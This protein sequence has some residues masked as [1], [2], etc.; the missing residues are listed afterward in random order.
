MS[1]HD[2]EMRQALADLLDEPTTDLDDVCLAIAVNQRLTNEVS[3]DTAIALYNDLSEMGNRGESKIG[4][5]HRDSLR[6]KYADMHPHDLM[7][8]MRTASIGLRQ[9]YADKLAKA[10]LKRQSVIVEQLRSNVQG[11]WDWLMS[12]ADGNMC[13]TVEVNRGVADVK[14]CPDDVNCQIIDND[15]LDEEE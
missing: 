4:E 2:D 13:V 12:L 1:L 8:D 5:P 9:V 3:F 15:I 7:E 14:S 10:M 6:S 11:S